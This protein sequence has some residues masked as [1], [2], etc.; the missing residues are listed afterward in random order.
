MRL[1]KPIDRRGANYESSVT[2]NIPA[3]SKIMLWI[4]P[5]DEVNNKA[6]QGN[7]NEIVSV[8]KPVAQ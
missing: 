6:L 8:P 4:I 7:N 1:K 3:E 5:E 2:F